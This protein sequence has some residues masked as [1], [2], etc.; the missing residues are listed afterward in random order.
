MTIGSN[1]S[2]ANVQSEL[3]A[4]SLWNAGTKTLN[5]CD[6]SGGGDTTP[7]ISLLAWANYNHA[8]S[9]PVPTGLVSQPG[10]P[11]NTNQ[12]TTIRLDWDLMACAENGYDV[13]R[14]TTSG[15]SYGKI[16]D[17]WASDNYSDSGYS[18]NT[19]RWYKL[20]SQG[21]VGE[22]G[23][24]SAVQGRT[25]PRYPGNG[26][27][28]VNAGNDC[29]DLDITVSWS[30][31]TSPGVRSS[32]ITWRWKKNAGSW[33]GWQGPTSQGISQII[34]NVGGGIVDDDVFYYEAYYTE[35]GTGAVST[36]QVTVICPI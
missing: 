12:D 13:Y 11:T 14:S 31:G 24:T 26:T 17:D 33:S 5:G 16:E 7:P 8:A 6:T 27:L 4:S 25:A 28:G 36:G 30:N 10:V 18:A 34:H 29:S 22:S 23:F 35:E 20:K 1:P 2:L 15:G 19:S 21:S 9:P 3:G 32:T